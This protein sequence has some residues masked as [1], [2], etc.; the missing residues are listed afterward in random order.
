MTSD[1]SFTPDNE[2][3]FIRFEANG[4]ILGANA[5]NSCEGTY[6]TGPDASLTITAVCTETACGTPA[7]WLGYP[8]ALA[9]S[10]VVVDDQV[11]LYNTDPHGEPW[12][13]VHA[14]GSALRRQ[15]S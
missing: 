15:S 11:I 6:P 4:T 14:R 1:I 5:C 3:Y 9:S 2:E 12:E 7:P 13:L 8:D 10:F